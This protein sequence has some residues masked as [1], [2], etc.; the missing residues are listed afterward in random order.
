VS[1]ACL[2]YYVLDFFINP[3]YYTARRQPRRVDRH[4]TLVE[5]VAVAVNCI[6]PRQCLRCTYIW[7]TNHGCA[8]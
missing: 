4:V 7:P 1:I 2:Y 8:S 3:Q 6:E 5:S